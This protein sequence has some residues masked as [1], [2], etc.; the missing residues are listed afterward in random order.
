MT[1]I[2]VRGIV[3]AFE[4]GNNILDGLSF[5]ITEGEHVGILGKNG[6]G[7]TTLLQILAGER[8]PEEGTV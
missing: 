6:A 2:S 5:E 7:K 3:K 4:E 8:D 1:D